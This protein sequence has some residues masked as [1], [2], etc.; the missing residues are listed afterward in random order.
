MI[1]AR[2]IRILEFKVLFLV[3]PL[4]LWWRREFAARN[5]WPV[6]VGTTL[7]CVLLAFRHPGF[8]W[9][10]GALTRP[11]LIRILV[12]T[13]VAGLV[14]VGFTRWAFP[15]LFLRFP[16][17]QPGVWLMVMLLYPV[18]SALPQEF[19]FRTFLFQRYRVL[20]SSERSLAL[21]SVVVF[22][23]AHVFFGNPVAPALTLVG[24]WLFTNTYRRS[25][26]SLLA[27]TLE[28][29]LLGNLVF[30][31]GLGWFFYRGS[32]AQLFAP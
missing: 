30:T 29:A 32:M 17:E 3:L 2:A 26:G 16:R 22:A 7:L 5:L 20:F 1:F 27:A 28:H 19:M 14:L 10:G 31:A 13:L 8:A 18:L 23:W 9:R 11:I 21:A 15:S 25:E 12:R 4:M 24:G 6:I